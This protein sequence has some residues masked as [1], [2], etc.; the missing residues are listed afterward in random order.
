MYIFDSYAILCCMSWF[1]VAQARKYPSPICTKVTEAQRNAPS[2]HLHLILVSVRCRSK[3]PRQ[4]QTQTLQTRRKI[5]GLNFAFMF[6]CFHCGCLWQGKC[7]QQQCANTVFLLPGM[8]LVQPSK[9][10]ANQSWGAACIGGNRSRPQG[11]ACALYAVVSFG[12]WLMLPCHLPPRASSSRLSSQSIMRL[13]TSVRYLRRESFDHGFISGYQWQLWSRC[14]QLSWLLWILFLNASK[15]FEYVWIC[16]KDDYTLKIF[17][18]C[19]NDH[20]NDQHV[21][22]LL[23]PPAVLLSRL[24]GKTCRIQSITAQQQHFE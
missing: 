22:G 20:Q 17:K 21:R 16:L 24:P 13:F 18:I 11:V 10:S 6:S 15:T 12:V 19:L 5:C 23:R 4:M 14:G 8:A 7:V 2:E 1:Y 9:W 3:S